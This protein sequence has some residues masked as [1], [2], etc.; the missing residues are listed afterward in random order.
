MKRAFLKKII[1]FSLSYGLIYMIWLGVFI[2]RGN[3]CDIYLSCY[4]FGTPAL[5]GDPLMI[6]FGLQAA[7]LIYLLRDSTRSWKRTLICFFPALIFYWLASQFLTA[8]IS[9]FIA[10]DLGFGLWEVTVFGI[11]LYVLE[12][13]SRAAGMMIALPLSLNLFNRDFWKRFAEKPA[14]EKV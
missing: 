10:D 11:E 7:F 14:V 12:L 1:M 2:A 8:L 3:A 9:Y 5:M 4:C 6:L 13:F